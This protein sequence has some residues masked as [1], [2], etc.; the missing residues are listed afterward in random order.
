[1]PS[2]LSSNKVTP[3]P[4]PD[5]IIEELPLHLHRHEPTTDKLHQPSASKLKMSPSSKLT[6][7]KV[8]TFDSGTPEEED[9]IPVGIFVLDF[10]GDY[11]YC[12]VLKLIHDSNLQKCRSMPH[13]KFKENEADGGCVLSTNYSLK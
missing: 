4:K 3:L 10:E 12:F 1:M 6:N 13:L 5:E 9:L 8:E 2:E 11:Y 7:Q